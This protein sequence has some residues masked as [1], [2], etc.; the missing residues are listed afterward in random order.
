MPVFRTL[1]VDDSPEFMRSV[2]HFLS[3]ETGIDVVGQASSGQE[4]LEQVRRLNPDL[5]LLDWM[6]P[7]LSGLEVT[8]KFKALPHAPRV[9]MLTGHDSPHYRG[10]AHA[11]GADGFLLK[12]EFG[13]KLLLLIESLRAVRG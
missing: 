3:G 11:A 12:E 8:R 5:V 2:A 6:M 13:A 9:I 7:G 1:L 10:A 4:A